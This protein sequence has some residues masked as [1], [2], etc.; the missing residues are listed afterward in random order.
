MGIDDRSSETQE[1]AA[2]IGLDWADQKHQIAE[3][4]VSTGRMSSYI[5]NHQPEDLQSWLGELRA[6]YGGARV[7]VV[8]EQSRGSLLYALMAC[9]FLDLY[10]VNPQSMASYRKTFKSSGAKSDVADAEML[11]EI[12]RKHP[13]RFRL[14]KPDDPD[15]RTLKLLTEGRRDQVNQVTR[16]TNKLTG[17]LKNYYPQALELAGELK[18]RQACEFLEHWTTLDDLKNAK[19]ARLR[20]FYKKYGRPRE[21]VLDSRIKLIKEAIPITRDPA[22]ILAG[23][24]TV[25]ALVAQIRALIQAIEE[26][27]DQIAQLFQKHPDCSIFDTLPGAGPA[28]A[29]RLLAAFGADRDRWQS[30]AE[31]QMLSGI[32]PVTFQSG[33]S[34]HVNWRLA[35][36]KFMR[37]TFHEFAAHSI[38]W[39]DWAHAYYLQLR[40]KGKGYHA[41]L[42]ALAFKWIRIIYRCWKTGTPYNDEVY[43]QSLEKRRSPLAPLVIQA[44]QKREEEEKEKAKAKGRR[45]TESQPGVAIA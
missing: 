16:L 12:V 36:P 1:V 33:N 24:M 4:T 39:C 6:R 14:L 30:A 8:L 45:K 42:R 19:P 23:V 15:T 11:S 31:I 37:Q 26:F 20:N 2:W 34:K 3:Y 28:L 43:T 22:A 44:R 41:A 5:V 35:C 18:S 27:D 7:A 32:A 9:D 25:R 21:E 17:H 40:S 29:P 13:E 38:I 10:P